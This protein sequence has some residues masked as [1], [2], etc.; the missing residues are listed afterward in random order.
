MSL[1]DRATIGTNNNYITFNDTASQ[2]YFRV[3][4]R[5]PQRRNIRELDLPIPFENGIADYRT[6]VGQVSYVIRGTMYPASESASD[7]GVEKLRKLASVEIAQDDATSDDGYVPYVWQEFNKQKQLFV[8]VLY[9]NVT[10]NTRQGLI[11][12]FELVCKVKD[13]TIF[14][15]PQK[16]AT[17]LEADPTATGSAVYSFTYPT[18]YGANL[19]SVSNVALN[20]GDLPTYPV[21][22]NVYG[23]ITDP[24]VTNNKTGEFIKLSSTTLGSQSNQL[25]IAYDKDSVAVTVD[26]VNRLSRVTSDSTFFKIQPGSNI[27]ELSGATVGSG[28]YMNLTYYDGWPLS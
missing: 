5:A 10:D 24:V 7:S 3:Q 16:S 21:S 2:P 23:P 8:K 22:I 20:S 17:T 26:G 11:K 13:P 19:L 28:A 14:G 27:L 25:V 12:D 15:Y 9:V 4:S 6:Y 1:Y 18:V